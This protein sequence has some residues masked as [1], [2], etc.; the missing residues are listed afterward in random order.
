MTKSELPIWSSN[1]FKANAILCVLVATALCLDEMSAQQRNIGMTFSYA[2]TGLEY[3][4]DIDD[5]NFVGVQLRAETSALFAFRSVYP[6]A[7]ASVFWNMIFKKMESANGNPIRFYAGPGL[8][9]G[10]SND[11]IGPPG[12]FF[13]LKGR[14]GGECTFARGVTISMNLSPML[15]GHFRINEGMVN[16]RLYRSG[17][18][19][20]IMPEVSIRYEF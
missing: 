3:C 16:M 1:M 5:D 4:F 19:Y 6:G 18:L 13:G 8:G 2:G 20:G 10:Y 15:G 7:S 14:V 17:L 12:M 9:I 11:I